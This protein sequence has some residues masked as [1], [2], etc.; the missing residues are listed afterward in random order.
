M[1]GTTYWSELFDECM[2]RHPARGPVSQYGLIRVGHTDVSCIRPPK[3]LPQLSFAQYDRIVFP[4]R[5]GHL[6]SVAILDVEHR[7]V[8]WYDAFGSCNIDQQVAS[9]VRLT[10]TVP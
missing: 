10:I 1:L 3:S 2:H 6:W 7:T 9:K 5:L 4:I 8:I